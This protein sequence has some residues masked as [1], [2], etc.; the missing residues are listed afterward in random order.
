MDEEAKDLPAPRGSGS[1]D[2]SGERGGM[3]ITRRQLF[4]GDKSESPIQQVRPV[5]LG[6]G[7]IKRSVSLYVCLIR[8]CT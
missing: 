2:G 6:G 3:N 7:G 8:A 5:F 4:P 1:S